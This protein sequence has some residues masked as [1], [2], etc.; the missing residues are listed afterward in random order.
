[1]YSDPALIGQVRVRL[2]PSST[3]APAQWSFDAPRSYLRIEVRDTGVG[4]AAAQLPHIFEEFYQVGVTPNSS[5]EGYGL[6]L[7]IV[8]R[9]ARLLDMKVEVKSVAGTGSEFS[10][11]LPI[12]QKADSMPAAIGVKAVPEVSPGGTFNLLLVEDEPGVLNAMRI[13]LKVEGYRVETASSAAEAL[14]LLRDGVDFDLIISDF[15]LEDGR[16]GTQ[17]IS[18]A[19]ELLGESLKAILVTGDTSSAVRE[20]QGDDKLRIASKPINSSEL[21][22]LVKSLLAQ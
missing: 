7:S 20:L 21:L 18:V 9:I 16:T 22:A 13:L 1:V 2:M 10:V 19:R 4:I 3:R 11:E 5:R 8:Q 6:G 12:A 14:E 15:H 17:V